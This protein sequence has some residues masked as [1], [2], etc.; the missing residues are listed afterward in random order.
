MG[1]INPLGTSQTNQ[2]SQQT[3]SSQPSQQLGETDFLNLLVTQL[4]NQDPL[5]PMD[6]TQFVTQLAT[7]S[8]L[9]QL[10]SINNGVTEL[11]NASQAAGSTASS[12]ASVQGT[13]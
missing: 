12:N 5:N 9:Q 10:I 11:A 2:S 4:E 8:S 13:S 3:T 6:D 7:F 1:S